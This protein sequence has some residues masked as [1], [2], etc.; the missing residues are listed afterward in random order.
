[1]SITRACLQTEQKHDKRHI[2]ENLWLVH[3]EG[4][5]ICLSLL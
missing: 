3:G 2:A 5:D 4:V 1:M